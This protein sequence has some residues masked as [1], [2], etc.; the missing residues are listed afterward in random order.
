M[1]RNSFQVK[2]QLVMKNDNISN[3]LTYNWFQLLFT[4]MCLSQKQYY[5]PS[6]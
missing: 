1:S 5:K 2:T 6:R 4:A 3:V